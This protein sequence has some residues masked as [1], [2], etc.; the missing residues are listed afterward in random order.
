MVYICLAETFLVNVPM[1]NGKISRW[2]RR[3]VRAIDRG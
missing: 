1:T 2:L 3:W